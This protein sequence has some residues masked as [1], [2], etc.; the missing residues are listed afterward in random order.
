[1]LRLEAAA[2]GA[3]LE[4]RDGGRVV[5]EDPRLREVGVGLGEARPVLLAAAC[6]CAGGGRRRARRR[7]AGAARAAPSTSRARR[8]RP[9]R[10]ARSDACCATLRQNEVL[11]MAGRAATI[12]RSPF[13]RPLVISSMSTKPVASPVTTSFDCESWSIVRKLSLTISRIDWKPVR[14]RFSAMSKIDFSAWSRSA[15]ASSSPSKHDCTMRLPAWIRFRRTAFS[16]MIRL[17]C[18]TFVMRGTPSTQRRQVGGAA[19]R[20]ERRLAHQLVLE[21]HEVDRLAALGERRHRVEDA[22]VRVAVEV[23]PGQEL[24]RGVEGLV[25]DQHRPEHGAL[26]L[27]VVRER[28]LP[29]GGLGGQ[30]SDDIR[31]GGRNGTGKIATERTNQTDNGPTKRTTETNNSRARASALGGGARRREG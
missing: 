15:A 30:G 6:R 18:S 17:Q 19:H 23:L 11:P 8:A 31:G 28:A 26:G 7:T 21:R 13:C 27:V 14:I 10:P 5:D 20:L 25:V 12:T 2:L 16:L 3:H 1:M 22:A 4:R 29:R 24:G 9:S